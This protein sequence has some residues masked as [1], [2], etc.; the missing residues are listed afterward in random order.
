MQFRKFHRESGISS[1]E[2]AREIFQMQPPRFKTYPRFPRTPLP[3]PRPITTPFS[4]LIENRRSE[5]KFENNGT[6]SLDD[7]STVLHSAAGLNSTRRDESLRPRHHPSGGG[8]YPLEYYVLSYRVQGLEPNVYHYAP[9]AHVLEHIQSTTLPK[10][11][12]VWPNPFHFSPAAVVVLTAVWGRS[13]PKYGEYAYRIALIEAGHSVQTALLAASGLGIEARPIGGIDQEK[14][15][16][17]LDVT[18]EEDPL[19]M[20]LLSR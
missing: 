14:M 3:T 15:T 11:D 2:N 6:L 5:F 1:L 8:I 4:E 19:Y 13:Y 18:G 16:H 10:L 9:E 7:I 17:A 20:F 12:D